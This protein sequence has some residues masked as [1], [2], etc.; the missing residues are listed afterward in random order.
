MKWQRKVRKIKKTVGRLVAQV[1]G[2]EPSLIA[3]TAGLWVFFILMLLI[4]SAQRL[5]SAATLLFI[6]GSAAFSAK[7][8]SAPVIITLIVQ[9]I[10]LFALTEHGLLVGLA[11]LCLQLT[12]SVG[13]R[14]LHHLSVIQ[15]DYRETKQN[16]IMKEAAAEFLPK[17]SDPRLIHLNIADP[18]EISRRS[19]G[20]LVETL[21]RSLNCHTVVFA[22]AS[23]D[24]RDFTTDSYATHDPD[25][26]ELGGFSIHQGRFTA[27]G[28][29]DKALVLRGRGDDNSWLPYYKLGAE[30]PTIS[31]VMAV[32]VF[33]HR[34]LIG[35]FFLDRADPVPFY[36]PD[37]AIV[38]RAR[39]IVCDFSSVSKELLK[40]SKTITHLSRL[41]QA[42]ARFNQATTIE[43]VYS[44][45]VTT[46]VNLTSFKH[47]ILSHRLEESKTFE[48]VA[49]TDPSFKELLGQ[50]H[51]QT[52]GLCSYAKKLGA[53][54]PAL[55][56]GA[57]VAV[58]PPFGKKIGLVLE[59]GEA[60]QMVPILA[61]D[62]LIAYLLMAG[63][64]MPTVSQVELLK[65]LGNLAAT[66]L[67]NAENHHQL[68]TL[69]TT[70][71]LT[72]L[73]NKRAFNQRM[74]EGMDRHLRRKEPLSLLY[75]DIDHFKRVND[76]KGHGVGDLVLKAFS[77]VINEAIRTVDLAGRYGGEEF[78]VLLEAT[79]R[80]AAFIIAE[81]IRG[82]MEELDLSHL[83]LRAKVTI[84]I[85]VASIPQ[86]C[87]SAAGLIEKA[88]QALYVAKRDGR[89]RCC[90]AA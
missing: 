39:Q 49:L 78:T 29:S 10:A 47:A 90:L 54:F 23:K 6:I 79:D 86:D 75:L 43:E 44:T 70:D 58:A 36:K 42:A 69:A 41:N 57:S 46:A 33:V 11:E 37:V 72:G 24:Q 83:G 55:R 34:Q 56:N 48:I 82:T 67:V 1:R 71:S 13:G 81:R 52:D 61:H 7:A 15:H 84:S 64:V 21:K 62:R 63:G 51:G 31:V 74:K 66:S 53:P 2:I 9:R 8:S 25:S 87:D 89:N 19:T 76:T 40:A 65:L 18:F 77:D 28:K 35:V 3:L 59:D 27:I 22:W 38:E 68:R 4:P 30:L 73:A 17:P 14:F 80:D 60:H 12:A 5:W 16:K 20:T 50:E 26:L 45:I 85:G 32:P 88:D